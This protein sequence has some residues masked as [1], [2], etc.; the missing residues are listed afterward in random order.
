MTLQEST[1]LSL[2]HGVQPKR[3]RMVDIAGEVCDRYGLSI[4][5]LLGKSRERRIAWPR[6]EAM[7][8]MRCE[9]FT[10]NQIGRYFGGMDHSSIWYGFHRHLER[11]ASVTE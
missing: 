3:R 7:Y 2:W 5:E 1:Y 4:T 11:L 8:L 10:L 6:Q 9:G